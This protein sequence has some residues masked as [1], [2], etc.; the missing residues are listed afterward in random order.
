MLECPAGMEFNAKGSA[1]PAT[2]NNP[3]AVEDCKLTPLETCEC[4]NGQVLNDVGKC[5]SLVMRAP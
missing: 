4:P 1:C 5:V 3:L 2:C